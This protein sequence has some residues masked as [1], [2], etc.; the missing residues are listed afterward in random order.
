M[1]VDE[2]T[3]WCYACEQRVLL[4]RRGVNNL[5]HFLLSVCTVGVWLIVWILNT[6]VRQPWRCSQCGSKNVRKGERG[7]RRGQRETEEFY[8]QD[9]R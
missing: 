8:A 9:E 5:L 4:H 2:E 3:G 1:A 6:L 7:I